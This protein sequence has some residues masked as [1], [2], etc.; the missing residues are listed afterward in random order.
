MREPRQP[1]DRPLPPPRRVGLQRR[2]RPGP[3]RRGR[4]SAD[5]ARPR[6]GRRGV[7][8]LGGLGIDALWSSPLRR[9]RRPPRPLPP[10]SGS[11]S[12]PTTTSDELREADGHGELTARNSASPL[13]VGMAEHPDDPD[14]APPG[15]ESFAD[16]ARPG[17]GAQAR[18]A[19]RTPTAVCSPSATGS[20]CGS[21]SSTASSPAT[22]ARPRCRG[23]GSCGRSTA[24]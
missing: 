9:A 4:R 7:R 22:S 3:A 17:R 15:G 19:R 20:C 11:R 23:C 16:D 2:A 8:N 12:K 21:S 5:R 13:V 24:A 6:P 10:S 18:A 1:R 14:Y